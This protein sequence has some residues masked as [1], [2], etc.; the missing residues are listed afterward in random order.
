V[1]DRLRLVVRRMADLGSTLVDALVRDNRVLPP[2]LAVL[3][4]FII[5]WILAGVFMGK[6]GQETVAHKADLGRSDL[7]QSDGGKSGGNPAPGVENRDVDS[8]A[9][10]RSKDPFREILAPENTNGERPSTTTPEQPTPETTTGPKT[11][12]AGG[13]NRD[14]DADGVPDRRERRV[15]TDPN[16]PDTDRD[17]TPDGSDDDANGDGRPDS[18][19]GGAGSGTGTGPGGTTGAGQPGRGGGRGQGGNGG[20]LLNSGGNLPLP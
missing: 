2:V 18:R 4:L 11:P 5:A 3:A 1:V 9:A 13:S 16:N 17:G 19:G 12:G 7:A 14:T 6:P 10:Y 20:G 8:Y 15:G